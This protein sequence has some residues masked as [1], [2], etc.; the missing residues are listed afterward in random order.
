MA[1]LPAGPADFGQKQ[2]MV[3]RPLWSAA[4]DCILPGSRKPCFAF[5]QNRRARRAARRQ[6]HSVEWK[7]VCCI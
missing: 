5:V 4:C 6:A 1:G 2:S 7:G 3:C